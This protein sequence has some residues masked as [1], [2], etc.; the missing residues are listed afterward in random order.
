MLIQ[1]AVAMPVNKN[2][3]SMHEVS[4]NDV[5][6]DGKMKVDLYDADHLLS[7]Q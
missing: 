3:S 2:T 4:V 5:P 6:R 7:E 1:H